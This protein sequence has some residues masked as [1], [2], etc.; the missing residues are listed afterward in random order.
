[1]IPACVVIANRKEFP[2][3]GG[4]YTSFR[5]TTITELDFSLF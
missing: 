3:A 5:D 2:E 4:N 1:M